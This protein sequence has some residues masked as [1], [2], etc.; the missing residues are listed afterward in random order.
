MVLVNYWR[1][2]KDSWASADKRELQ[3]WKRYRLLSHDNSGIGHVGSNAWMDKEMGK[4]TIIF[5]F[6]L[7]LL[8]INHHSSV[9]SV[10]SDSLQPHGLHHAGFPC[11]SSTPGTYSNSC[12]SCRWCYPTISSSVIPFSYF[13][14]FPLSG[15]FPV[16]WFFALGSQSIGVSASASVLPVNIQ[17]WFSLGWTDWISLQSKGLSRVF[18][19]TVQKHQL[20]GAQLSLMSQLSHPYTTTGKTIALTKWTFVDK[21]ISLL[22]NMLSRLVIA[23]LPRSKHLLISWLQSPSA[24]IWEPQKIKSVTVS[25]VSPS[26]SHEVM[27]SDAM[28]LV[29]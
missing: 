4:Q 29:F 26:I 20:F 10:M 8:Y 13:Q 14:S 12:P 6:T 15:S 11:P 5:S 25:I 1:Y 19:T 23:F 17:D 9:Q 3:V 22:F 21:V 27:W 16:G 28:I 2:D 24:V 7:V 18:N